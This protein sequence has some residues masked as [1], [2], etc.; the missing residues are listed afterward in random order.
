MH[1]LVQVWLESSLPAV[2]R[3]TPPGRAQPSMLA[4]VMEQGVRETQFEI[5]L[6]P[7]PAS[8][9]RLACSLVASPVA[10]MVKNP[11]TTG[12]TRVVSLGGEDPLEKGRTTHSSILAWRIPWSEEPGGVQSLGFQAVWHGWVTDPFTV[13]LVQWFPSTRMAQNEMISKIYVAHSRYKAR[14]QPQMA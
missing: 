12:E 14:S 7:W 5:H 11:P 8:L 4:G 13:S 9:C 10:Q 1:R 3:F 6:C 2:V